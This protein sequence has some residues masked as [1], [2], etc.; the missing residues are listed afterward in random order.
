[1]PADPRLQYVPRSSPIP[2]RNAAPHPSNDAIAGARR[3]SL[4][5]RSRLAHN[6]AD[7]ARAGRE[8]DNPATSRTKDRLAFSSSYSSFYAQLPSVLCQILIQ[9]LQ[10]DLAIGIRQHAVFDLPQS[11]LPMHMLD[12]CSVYSI[13]PPPQPPMPQHETHH[14]VPLP[15]TELFPG[16]RHKLIVLDRL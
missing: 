11:L 16:P 10:N 3:A 2:R 4:S 14:I 13:Q 12:H 9:H 5:P 15:P 8:I 6:R 7:T 1:M